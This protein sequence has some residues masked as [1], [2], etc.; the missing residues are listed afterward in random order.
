MFQ[1]RPFWLSPVIVVLALLVSCSA[2]RPDVSGDAPVDLRLH[3]KP[4]AR[5]RFW[6]ESAQRIEQPMLGDGITQRFGIGTTY[7]VL[8]VDSAG[9]A[10]LRVTFDSVAFFQDGVIG[11]AEYNSGNP[12]AEIPPMAVGFAALFGEGF[13][14]RVAPDGQVLGV[15][16]ID[17]L[18]ERMRGKLEKQAEGAEMS[19]ISGLRRIDPQWLKGMVEGAFSYLPEQPIAVGEF[20]DGA[21]PSGQGFAVPI[22]NRYRLE[23][24]NDGVATI[25]VE[26]AAESGDAEGTSGQMGGFTYKITGKQEGTMT[27]ELGTGMPIGSEVE[28]SYSGELQVKGGSGK[29]YPV[30][31][32]GTTKLRRVGS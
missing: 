32:E 15:E 2:E 30:S 5:Y 18:W 19:V 28:Q 16:G 10:S 29:G 4:G 17:S 1:T 14:A 25:A 12:S 24:V 21:A 6:S 23:S 8:G 26:S 3:L 22:R 27:I 31:L 13:T 11:T 9:V 7:H 20:W